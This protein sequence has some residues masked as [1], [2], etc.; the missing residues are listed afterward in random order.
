MCFIC[1]HFICYFHLKTDDWL[2]GILER[3]WDCVCFW[4]WISKLRKKNFQIL[5]KGR[6]R[7]KQSV[8]IYQVHGKHVFMM[9][10]SV[11][12]SGATDLTKLYMDPSPKLE[13]H[14]VHGDIS[15]YVPVISILSYLITMRF[16]FPPFQYLYILF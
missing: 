11:G 1:S 14:S 16:L 2:V 8:N 5:W 7:R 10:E 3:T 12:T 15:L 9:A 4:Q 6:K 13:R